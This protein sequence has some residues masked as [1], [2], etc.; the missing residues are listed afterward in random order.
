MSNIKYLGFAK[1]TSSVPICGRESN[2]ED[3]KLE[4]TKVERAS[5]RFSRS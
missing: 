3:L 2:E 4:T 1:A 5:A